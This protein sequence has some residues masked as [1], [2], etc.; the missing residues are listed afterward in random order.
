MDEVELQLLLLNPKL[1]IYL[2]N[3]TKFSRISFNVSYVTHFIMG[4]FTF[5]ACGPNYIILT[6]LTAVW[7]I[8]VCG[9]LPIY[10]AIFPGSFLVQNF[11]A[12]VRGDVEGYDRF[13]MGR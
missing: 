7:S 6:S 1:T 5:A 10:S 3:I 12:D 13:K 9:N 4:L 2:N 8:R 11:A